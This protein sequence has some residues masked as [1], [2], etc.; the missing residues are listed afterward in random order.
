M[1]L[2]KASRQSEIR[3]L[4]ELENRGDV[5]FFLGDP[6]SD[7]G[8]KTTVERGNV[9]SPGLWSAG[10]STV[11]ILED[12]LISVEELPSEEIAWSFMATEN[13]LP[14]SKS[15][16]RIA[17]MQFWTELFFLG[18]PGSGGSDFLRVRCL[19]PSS[20][21]GILVRSCGPAGRRIDRMTAV[22]NGVCF[23]EG[24]AVQ[25]LNG[26]CEVLIFTPE[27]TGGGFAALLV[28]AAPD[29]RYDFRIAH[30]G[31]PAFLT[32]RNRRIRTMSLDGAREVLHQDCRGRQLPKIACP[33]RRL[34][35]AWQ[36]LAYHLLAAMECGSPRIGVANYPFVWLRDGVAML[37]AL[38]YLGLSELAARGVREV[39]ALDFCG[40]FGAESDA[41]GEGIHAIVFH[42]FFQ[43]NR[44]LLEECFPAIER[45]V[46]CLL[47]MLTARDIRFLAA[48]GKNL[49]HLRSPGANLLCFPA[50]HGWIHGRMDGHSPDFY[51]NAW[52]W[53]GLDAAVAAAGWLGRPKE[54]E[55]W[56]GIREKLAGAIR[57][58]WPA[59]ASNERDLIIF[60]HPTGLFG[61]DGCRPA[62]QARFLRQFRHKYL[63]GRNERIPEKLWPYFEVAAAHNALLL[64]AGE[65]AWILLN[66]L[67]EEMGECGIY[68]EGP[69]NGNEM[70]PFGNY[71][72]EM[73]G[74]LSPERA[75][76]GN[77]PHNWT[78][79][80]MIALLRALLIAET[81]DGLLWGRGLPAAWARKDAV[82][83]LEAMPTAFGRVSGS[84]RFT[85]REW[86][87]EDYQGPPLCHR[88]AGCPAGG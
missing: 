28:P 65:E 54:A 68:T 39:A 1:T 35:I 64:G 3:R 25:L 31:P 23:G 10:I 55:A 66:G 51:I 76:A 42:T 81:P 62:A 70:L 77:M 15:S 6:Q 58:N 86:R 46:G 37:E 63:T 8:D 24:T 33:D 4:V 7:T 18:G 52:A 69:P 16:F 17:G 45:K 84:L 59:E 5:H 19:A 40:G 26:N 38:D 32:E 73:A 22:E 75:V 44:D 27:E 29:H 41:P 57:K 2:D 67:L 78:N 47:E 34:N 48:P 21:W 80:E 87:L 79:A 12:K 61:S 82:V 74:W 13:A 85:G 43:R 60:P 14:I 56:S 36:C 11:R 50:R 9:F 72:A 71:P 30:A 83:R 53:R 20:G 49:A 88:V